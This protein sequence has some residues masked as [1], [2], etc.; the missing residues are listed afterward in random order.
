MIKIIHIITDL[1]TGGA[2][3]MLYKVLSKTDRNRFEPVVISLSDHGTL[4]E[5]IEGLDIPVIDIGMKRGRPTLIGILRLITISRE[6]KPNIIQGWMY[7]GNLAAQIADLFTPGQTFVLWNI[8]Q[9]LYSLLY[10]KRLTAAVI[11]LGSYLSRF[12]EYIIYNSKTSASQHEAIG[13]RANA[14][15]FI[16]NGFDTDHFVPS[17]EA[18]I[19]VRSELGITGDV[20][21]IG[22]ICRYHPMKD[23]LNFLKAASLLLKK[24]SNVHFILAGDQVDESNSELCEKIHDLQLSNQVH[25][26]GERRDIPR[27]VA[28]LDIAVSSSYYAEAFPNVVGE[29]MSCAVPCVVTDVGD[30]AFIVGDTGRV[31]QPRDP[32]ALA[33]ACSELISLNAYQRRDLGLKARQ[34]ILEHFSLDAVVRQYEA[35]YEKIAAKRGS[36][37]ACAA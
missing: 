15:V 10:E 13:Y 8:R 12:P 16:P 11:K 24:H 29:A 27:L 33:D 2:E 35:L 4:G 1:S 34:R 37:A 22:L 3:M 7:H 18:K 26:L 30:S 6:L 31:V 36:I 14:R 28:A 20:F 25:L 9:S 17:D 19:S 32:Q 21:L 5:R 23:H